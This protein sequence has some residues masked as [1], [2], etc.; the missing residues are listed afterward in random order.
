MLLGVNRLPERGARCVTDERVLRP[1]R[2]CR[3]GRRP[4]GSPADATP[5]ALQRHG[6]FRL[7]GCPV[8]GSRAQIRVGRNGGPARKGAFPWV[9]GDRQAV[10][11]RAQRDRRCRPFG[12]R[13]LPSVRLPCDGPPS[14]DAARHDRTASQAGTQSSTAAPFSPAPGAHRPDQTISSAERVNVPA[15]LRV[16]DSTVPSSNVGP[17]CHCSVALVSRRRPV[18][19]TSML[20]PWSRMRSSVSGLSSRI[21]ATTESARPPQILSTGPTGQFMARAN[22]LYRRSALEHTAPLNGHS[23]GDGVLPALRQSLC[24]GRSGDSAGSSAVGHRPVGGSRCPRCTAVQ[25]PAR[26][27]PPSYDRAYPRRVSAGRV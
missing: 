26:D 14:V 1:P 5:R 21:A 24:S 18:A 3:A 13:P 7:N 15:E 11:V 27:R 22:Q 17:R 20:K 12:G 23:S 19:R 25:N 16:M 10:E 2:P 9:G 6:T 8:A 4:A